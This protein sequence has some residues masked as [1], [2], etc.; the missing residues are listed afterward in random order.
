MGRKP[1]FYVFYDENDFVKCCGTPKQLVEQGA[2]NN[3][4]YVPEL[5]HKIKKKIVKGNVV[6]LP[7]TE[8]EV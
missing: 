4:S 5:A 2:F 1:L 7:L 3:I 6:V 8:K